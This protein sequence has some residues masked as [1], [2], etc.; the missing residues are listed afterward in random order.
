M[1]GSSEYTEAMRHFSTVNVQ[2]SACVVQP[3]TQEHVGAIVRVF[4]PSSTIHSQHLRL[5]FG[6]SRHYP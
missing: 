3:A 2:Q 1:L 5:P 6:S 4:S